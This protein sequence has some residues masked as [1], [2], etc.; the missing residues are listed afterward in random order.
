MMLD[1]LQPAAVSSLA[2]TVVR[3][4]QVVDPELLGLVEAR[5]SL[6][7]E[8]IGPDLG[9]HELTA[10]DRDCLA[11]VD[12]MLV[13]VANLSDETAKGASRHFPDGGFSDFVTAAYL[14]EAHVRLGIATGLLL[15][16]RS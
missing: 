13:D 12:Q 15:G 10:R 6:R 9:D 2:M 1:D 7:L 16:G 4:R 8:G 14:I 5:I 11:V 3:A